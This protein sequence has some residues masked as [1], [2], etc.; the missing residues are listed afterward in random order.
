MAARARLMGT[1]DWA[2]EGR[3][4][5][6]PTL[7]V[8][9]DPDLDHV[10]PATGTSEYVGLIGGARYA[11]LAHT[12]HL[13]CITRPQEFAAIVCAFARTAQRSRGANPHAA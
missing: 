1:I 2:A 11:R 4:I 5:S 13:G 7:V 8:T 9:G 3:T 12:G 6:T 10:V